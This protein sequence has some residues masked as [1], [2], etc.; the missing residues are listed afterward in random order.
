MNVA[1][2]LPDIFIR[3]G[4]GNDALSASAGSNV[5]DG[6][7]DTFFLDGTAGATWDTVANFHPGDSVTLWG[8][9]PGTSTLAWAAN[10]G[11]AR[12]T[13]PPSIR[14]SPARAPRSTAPSPLPA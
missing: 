2:N 9:V 4:A 13:G 10:E 5:L 11:A 8:F 12:H 14:P 1:A 3:G 7:R 6:G